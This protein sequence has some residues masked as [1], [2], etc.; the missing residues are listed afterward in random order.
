[1]CIVNLWQGSQIIILCG[2]E[3]AWGC[4]RQ[5]H[6]KFIAWAIIDGCRANGLSRWKWK[7]GEGAFGGMIPSWNH[8]LV[9]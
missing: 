8:T 4:D 7:G 6:S 3:E 5:T 2:K 1:M 9:K